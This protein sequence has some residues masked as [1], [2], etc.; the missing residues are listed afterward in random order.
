[1][2]TKKIKIN[3]IMSIIIGKQL[4]TEN[5]YELVD[6]LTGQRN[7]PYTF[8]RAM[9][10]IRPY[11]NSTINFNKKQKLIINRFISNVNLSEND[12]LNTIEQEF[13]KEYEIQGPMPG[14]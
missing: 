11:L 9:K 1:M 2:K 3:D 4:P 12:I 6:Y 8:S 14:W 5:C 7:F 13:E 10:C